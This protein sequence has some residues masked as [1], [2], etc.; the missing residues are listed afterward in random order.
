[1]VTAKKRRFFMYPFSIVMA[2]CAFLIVFNQPLYAKE[3]LKGPIEAKVVEVIDGDTLHVLAK[4]WLGQEISIRV[5]LSNIDTP[6]LRGKCAAEKEL[7]LE[8]KN[9]MKMKTLSKTVILTN[10]QY[11]KYAGRV[12]ADVSFLDNTPVDTSLREAGLARNYD[13]GKRQTWC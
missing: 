9:M 11:E 7:A 5:R 13:G 8:A 6:E 4:I 10:I 2:L 1:M 12:L 3:V